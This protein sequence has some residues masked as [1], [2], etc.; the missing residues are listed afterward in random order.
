[1]CLY[2][3]FHRI[4]HTFSANENSYFVKLT[5][6]EVIC[7]LQRGIEAWDLWEGARR[8]A[9]RV[10]NVPGTVWAVDTRGNTLACAHTDR[11]ITMWDL[12]NERPGRGPASCSEWIHSILV[13][14]SDTVLTGLRNGEVEVWST[15]AAGTCALAR[16]RKLERHKE[17]VTCMQV[18]NPILFYC[19]LL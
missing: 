5:D 14:D 6:Q 11:T 13:Y 3:N 2:L 19:L 17:A 10:P 8:P 16:V 15:T 9:D 4:V 1:M 7:G 12:K 18:E